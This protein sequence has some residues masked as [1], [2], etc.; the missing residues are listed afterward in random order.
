MKP[1]NHPYPSGRRGAPNRRFL[2]LVA[3]VVL[4]A[5]LMIGACLALASCSGNIFL[6]SRAVETPS[7]GVWRFDEH[8]GGGFS[9]IIVQRDGRIRVVGARVLAEQAG[10][11]ASESVED[12]YYNWSTG[13]K[14]SIVLEGDRLAAWPLPEKFGNGVTWSKISVNPCGIELRD[15]LVW[16]LRL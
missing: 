4:L 1:S 16:M 6:N 14:G 8:P 2:A 5:T 7:F 10:C 13:S 15:G 9:E 3:G 12:G 11:P